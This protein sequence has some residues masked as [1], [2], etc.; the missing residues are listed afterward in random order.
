M[1]HPDVTAIILAAGKGTRMGSDLAKVLHPLAGRPLVAHVLATCRT[2]GVARSVCVVGW[3]RDAVE[4][5]V[6]PLGATCVL[7]DRQLGTGHAVLCAKAAIATG[8][9]LVLCGDCPMTP[10]SLLDE[11]LAKHRDSGAACTAIAARMADPGRYGRM[12]TAADGRLARIVEWK[13]AS[14]EQRRVDLINSGIYAFR[15]ADLFRCL[16]RVKPD[17][18][19]GEYYLTD[20]VGMLVAEGQPVELVVTTDMSAVLGV[21]TPQ[22]LADA[23]TLF[24]RR[25]AAAG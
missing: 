1:P 18:A 8:T 2:L 5:L 24:H 25:A 21:N 22:D 20:V 11:V 6:R 12:I 4:S 13:D 7:Q 16:E 23:E 3:Q 14:E 9:V 10:A 17:N 19:Q 15:A